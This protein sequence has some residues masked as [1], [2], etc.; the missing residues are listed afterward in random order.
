MKLADNDTH[1]PTGE[2]SNTGIVKQTQTNAYIQ[3]D[4]GEGQSVN[5]NTFSGQ[6]NS[7]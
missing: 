1:T 7:I 6:L 2:Y 5:S 3:T 4:L